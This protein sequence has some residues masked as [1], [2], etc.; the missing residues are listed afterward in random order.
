MIARIALF[1]CWLLLMTGKYCIY[2][3]KY[4]LDCGH[5]LYMRLK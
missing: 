4:F 1:H 5:D 3:G 2:A